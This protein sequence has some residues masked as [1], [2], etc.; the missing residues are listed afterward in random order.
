MH[1]KVKFIVVLRNHI[2]FVFYDTVI[3]TRE[4]S[5]QNE[6]SRTPFFA[7]VL[8]GIIQSICV[9]VTDGAMYKPSINKQTNL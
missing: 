5:V 2:D 4:Q 7:S 6:K 1:F 8:V 9:L 3:K